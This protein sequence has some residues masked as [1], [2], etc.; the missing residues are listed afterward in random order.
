MA[1]HDAG[2]W[3]HQRGGALQRGLQAHGLFARD[4]LQVVHAVG[5][6]ALRDALQLRGLLRAGGHDE[7]AQALVRHAPFGAIRIEQVLAAHAEAGL[8]AAR[9]VVDAGV[10]DFGVARAGAGA[11][12]LGGFR[13]QH[14]AAGLGQRAGDRQADH[15]G[16]DDDAIDVGA[17]CVFLS[18]RAPAGVRSNPPA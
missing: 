5:A 7:L 3:R 11:D 12:G 6:G 18:D 9:R 13:H 15:A 1:V 14:L 4:V 16:A 17:H 2:R 10:Y 8:E